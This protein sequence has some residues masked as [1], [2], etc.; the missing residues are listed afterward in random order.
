MNLS[1]ESSKNNLSTRIVVQFLR[2]FFDLD[3]KENGNQELLIVLGAWRTFLGL[4]VMILHV[5]AELVS[6]RI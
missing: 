5:S 6:L 3:V 2:V 1:S 4:S